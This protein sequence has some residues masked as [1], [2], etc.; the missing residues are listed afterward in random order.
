[1]A[2]DKYFSGSPKDGLKHYNISNY[3][4]QLNVCS[5]DRL[6]TQRVTLLI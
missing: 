4:M 3:I 2:L 6:M 1:M 5:G